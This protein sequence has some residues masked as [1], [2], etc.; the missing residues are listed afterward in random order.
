MAVDRRIAKARALAAKK[1]KQYGDLHAVSGRTNYTEKYWSSGSLTLDYIMGTMGYPDNGFVEVYGPPSI[2][3][4]SAFGYAG[5][6]RS[7]QQGG[8]ITAVIAMEPKIN[9]AWLERLGV[10]PDLNVI[11]R[12]NTGE[13]AWNMAFE[14]VKDAEADYFVFDSIGSVSSEKEQNAEKAQAYGNSALNT[15][16]VLRLPPYAWKTHVGGMFINQVR[17][18]TK[19]RIAGMKESPGGHALKHAFEIRLEAK[20]GKDRHTRKIKGVE[21][22]EELV[23]GQEIRALIK[24]DKAGEE[25]AKRATFDFYTIESEDGTFGID[26]AKDA[27]TAG[28]LSGVVKGTGWLTWD[29]FPDGKIQGKTNAREVLKDEALQNKMREDVT[30]ALKGKSDIDLIEE[31]VGAIEGDDDSDE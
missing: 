29:G 23:I 6:L 18:D 15:W 28:I 14:L 16:G 20:P 24:K 27:L 5:V 4:S 3:K 9:E 10:D 2:G 13:E 19:S 30:K 7:V 11:L 25:R 31:S 26:R 12:P 21:G 17:D 1:Q 22:T 8:G